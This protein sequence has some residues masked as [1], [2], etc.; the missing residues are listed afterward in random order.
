MNQSKLYIKKGNQSDR[1]IH[2]IFGNDNPKDKLI[3]YKY[4]NGECRL[5]R[6]NID[7]RVERKN[8]NIYVV[9]LHVFGRYILSEIEIHKSDDKWVAICSDD[10]KSDKN[11][12]IAVAKLAYNSGMRI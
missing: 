8:K 2:Y 6:L 5:P 11:K 12:F 4:T 3:V 9:Y 1:N 10:R 7:F